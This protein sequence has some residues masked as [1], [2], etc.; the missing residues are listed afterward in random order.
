MIGAS[1]GD[2]RV[3]EL[4][5]RLEYKYSV[6]SDG[7]FR[8]LFDMGEERSQLAIISSKTYELGSL[9]IREVWSVGYECDGPLPEAVAN[10][11]L[12]QNNQVKLGAWRVMRY[13]SGR[14]L[15]AFAVQIAANTDAHTLRTTITAVLK[16]A[17]DTERE[18]SGGDTF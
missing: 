17:D 10:Y 16:T 2:K 15:A 11:L 7:D 9:E 6:D 14:H 5:D 4:L 8:V 18:L 12:R 3:Q 1:A 13:E